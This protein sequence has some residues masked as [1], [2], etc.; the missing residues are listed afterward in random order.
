MPQSFQPELRPYSRVEWLLIN[1]WL[2]FSEPGPNGQ[3]QAG[4]DPLMQ[5]LE[6]FLQDEGLI[7][8]DGVPNG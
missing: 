8:E 7:G 2:A 5:E 4:H 6:A 3:M 1:L